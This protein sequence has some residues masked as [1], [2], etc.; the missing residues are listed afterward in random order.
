MILKTKG[1]GLL[2]KQ[3]FSDIGFIYI[4]T[5]FFNNFLNQNDRKYFLLLR[6]KYDDGSFKTLHKGVVLN[7]DSLNDYIKYCHNNLSIKSNDYTTEMV[8]EIFFNYFIID[9]EREKY[10]IYRWSELLPSSLNKPIKLEKFSNGIITTKLALN[11]DYLTWGIIL[12]N[13][14]LIKIISSDLGTFIITKEGESN[15]IQL[16][17]D[18]R[19]IIRFTDTDY[20]SN[21]GI[22]IRKMRTDSM[23]VNYYISEGGTIF[24]ITKEDLKTKFLTRL[25]KQTRYYPKI[26]T[27]DIETIVKNG[28]HKPYLFSM[29]DGKKAY[30][31][32]SDSPEPLFNQLLKPKYRGYSVYA[33][34][35]S[36]FDIF[37]LLGYIADL[38]TD[39]KYS[40]KPYINTAGKFISIKIYNSQRNVSI[41]IKDSYLLLPASLQK[42]AI[43]FN[44]TIQKGVEPVYIG[45]TKSVYYMEDLSHY[46]KR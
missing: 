11:R 45:D 20:P 18:S 10:Y 12:R 43:Q 40:V 15:M 13:T 9:K 32:F 23:L 42:L 27:I 24:L 3:I 46:N 26:I 44:T 30:S 14:D 41:I 33:H 6:L 8:G 1:L 38:E 16:I 29:Y 39:G 19:E 25:K 21:P 2:F 37:F 5:H 35:L 31:W 7:L 34:N 36:M 22:F 4:I 17:K 28:I